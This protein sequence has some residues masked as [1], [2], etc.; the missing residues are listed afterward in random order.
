MTP[1]QTP[2]NV[3]VEAQ[4][5]AAGDNAK[6][7]HFVL[8]G[9]HL[10]NAL[11]SITQMLPNCPLSLANPN[12]EKVKTMTFILA[13]AE[14]SDLIF[15]CHRSFAFIFTCFLHICFSQAT[16]A[17]CLVYFLCICPH[18]Y[19]FTHAFWEVRKTQLFPF[20]LYNLN[21]NYILIIFFSFPV[22]S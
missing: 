10:H 13:E 5:F 15:C 9:P 18:A 17:L 1:C 8:I 11:Q 22:Y 21:D 16:Q 14:K 12:T 6:N 19:V 4:S 20:K 3:R 2:S 7:L